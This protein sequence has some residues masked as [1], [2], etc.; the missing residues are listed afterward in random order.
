MAGLGGDPAAHRQGP[1]I[2]GAA[3]LQQIAVQP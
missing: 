1:G 2:I 3:Q